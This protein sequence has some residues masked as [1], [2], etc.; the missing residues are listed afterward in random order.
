LTALYIPLLG[1]FLSLF[2]AVPLLG[3][4]LYAGQRIG[5]GVVLFVTVTI[6]LGIGIQESLLFCVQYGIM[7]L[8]LAAGIQRRWSPERSIITAVGTSLGIATILLTGYFGWQQINPV[9]L[10]QQAIKTS[11]TQTITAYQAQG[12]NTEQIHFLQEYI[13]QVINFFLY[14]FP[15]LVII[16]LFIVSSLSYF[17]V[18]MMWQKWSQEARFPVFS[19]AH[20]TLSEYVIWGLIVAG[21]LS[22]LPMAPLRFFAQ[23]CL[24]VVLF[25]YLL[26]GLVIIH[27]YLQKGK[28]PPLLRG[29]GYVLL[30]VQPLFL[31]IVV[32][33]GVFD[34]WV[35]FRRIRVK[36]AG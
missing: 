5:G 27:F 21:F 2:S 17:V 18:Y 31:L 6:A 24:L 26:Q 20:W 22:F 33:L 14:S 7:A 36:T 4:S 23:N 32:A 8:V 35:D 9:P 1:I 15:A 30:L 25:G 29:V 16:G 19:L 3:I 13:G 12:L 11:I 28:I 34:L 10:L